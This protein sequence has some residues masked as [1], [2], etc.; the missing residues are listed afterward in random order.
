MIETKNE[1]IIVINATNEKKVNKTTVNE[2]TI[3]N[4]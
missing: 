1:K 2:K 3:K 4:K